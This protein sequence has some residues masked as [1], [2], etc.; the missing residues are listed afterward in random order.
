MQENILTMEGDRAKEISHAQ[1]K[2]AFQVRS[3]R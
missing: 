2:R 3:D 1:I